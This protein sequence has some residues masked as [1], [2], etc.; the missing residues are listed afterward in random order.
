MLTVLGFQYNSSFYGTNIKELLASFRLFS[1]SQNSLLRNPKLN[2]LIRKT[3]PQDNVHLIPV[4][5]IIPMLCNGCKMLCNKLCMIHLLP[6]QEISLSCYGC[7]QHFCW[8]YLNGSIQCVK[9]YDTRKG[10]TNWSA[11]LNLKFL[12]G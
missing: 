8:F 2:H 1:W 6:H 5:P 3:S 9:T 12:V 10:R 11:L 7:T 4:Q